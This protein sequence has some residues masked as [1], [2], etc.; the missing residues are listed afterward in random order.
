MLQ[1]YGMTENAAAAMVQPDG[2]AAAG[3]IGGPIPCT[4]VASLPTT[5]CA[6]PCCVILMLPLYTATQYG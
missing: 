3:N 1:G 6:V 5:P 4:E 2:Y